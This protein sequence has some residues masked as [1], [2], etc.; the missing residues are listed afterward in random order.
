MKRGF[1]KEGVV[2]IDFVAG[3][4][5]S[6]N[7][8]RA[9]IRHSS[10]RIESER[11]AAA[12]RTTRCC[13]FYNAAAP[14]TML[15]I[16]SRVRASRA[17]I[18]KYM[19]L[20]CIYPVRRMPSI[21]VAPDDVLTV[22]DGFSARVWDS[23]SRYTPAQ[24]Y[25]VGETGIYVDTPPKKIWAERGRSSEVATSQKHSLRMREYGS[26]QACV[27]G[28][29]LQYI[30]HPVSS[31]RDKRRVLINRAIQACEDTQHLSTVVRSSFER[32]AECT[33]MVLTWSARFLSCFMMCLWCCLQDTEKAKA[34][35]SQC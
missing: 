12:R 8:E 23:Y 7:D 22:R 20:H 32:L 11:R 15:H 21:Q 33:C 28:L 18:V 34:Q 4:V 5:M 25:N 10:P 29:W 1:R 19:W 35:L 6:I 3:L 24:V 26:L 17:N 16:S 9:A 14:C 13:A 27:R 2:K 30:N 31:A